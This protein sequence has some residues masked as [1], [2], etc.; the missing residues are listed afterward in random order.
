MD[1]GITIEDIENL[2]KL[3][4]YSPF[5]NELDEKYPIG[6]ITSDENLRDIAAGKVSQFQWV[7][8][9]SNSPAKNT[10]AESIMGEIVTHSVYAGQWV[11][12]PVVV[13]EDFKPVELPDGT[14]IEFPQSTWDFTKGAEIL[15]EKGLAKIVIDDDGG[16]MIS[17]TEEM[18]KFIAGRLK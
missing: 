4:E 17:P 3:P 6:N 15:V 8:A 1:S 12:I 18:I 14:K 9:F 2:G 7:R 13:N 5:H 16:E 11:D 10:E